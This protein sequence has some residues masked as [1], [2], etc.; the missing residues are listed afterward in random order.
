MA[1]PLTAVALLVFLWTLRGAAA[2]PSPLRFFFVVSLFPVLGFVNLYGALYSWV[3]DHWQYLPD[4]GPLALAGAGLEWVC[5]RT[6]GRWFASALLVV[7][8]G[9][10]WAHCAMFK[11]DETLFRSTIA[12]N[13][14]AWMAHT[15]L[16]IIL[17]AVPADCS[18]RSRSSRPR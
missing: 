5:D 15:N 11:D 10:T 16:G 4:L 7:L 12:R 13:P 3:W 9:L 2:R 18:R 8:G 17:K 1:V 6:W 14:G